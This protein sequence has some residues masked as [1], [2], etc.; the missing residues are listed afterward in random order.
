MKKLNLKALLLLMRPKQWTKNLFV[1]GAIIFSG[2][3]LNA[4]LV[5][6][7]LFVFA[8]FCLTSSSVYVFNDIVDADKDRKHPIKKYRPIASGKV[9][10]G[11]GIILDVILLIFIITFTSI[12]NIKIL[13]LLMMYVVMNIFYSFILKNVVIIDVMIITAGFVMRLA[14]GGIATSVELSPWIILC[15][16]LLALFIALNKR[17]SEI[18]SM[19]ENRTKTRKILEEYSVELI[20][21]M[22]TI[23]TPSILMAY[24]LYT[25]SSIQNRSM[26]ITIPFVLYGIFRYEYLMEKAN[27]GGKPEDIFTK[28]MPF[29]VNIVCWFLVVIIVIYFKL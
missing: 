14:S 28:D 8:M 5:L 13:I 11:Q 24:C 9:S 6:M 2:N 4:R 25:F 17:K 12:V 3:F 1:F 22:L 29:L 18:I 21:K 26:M 10:K 19:K 20:D 15:T 7:N 27:I 16:I 23:V